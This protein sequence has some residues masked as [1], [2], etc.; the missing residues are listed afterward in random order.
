MAKVWNLVWWTAAIGLLCLGVWISGRALLH[1]GGGMVSFFEGQLHNRE[2]VGNRWGTE[3]EYKVGQ[4]ANAFVC[5][6]IGGGILVG[7]W[8][9]YQ[10]KP[11]TDK[12]DKLYG[13]GQYKQQS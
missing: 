9:H 10:P 1:S 3:R 13:R 8:E 6:V 4:F 12:W 2:W 11:G 5:F 7:L